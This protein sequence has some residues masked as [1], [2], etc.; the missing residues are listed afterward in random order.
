M[1]NLYNIKKL[2]IKRYIMVFKSSITKEVLYTFIN[3]AWR[4]ISGPL[5]LIFIP[6][7]LTPQIQGYWYTFG[8]LAALSVLADLGFTTIVSQFSA[9]EFA[10]LKFG[11][12]ELLEG[13]ED[14]LKRLGS[15]LRFVSKWAGSVCLVAFPVI[16]TTGFLM[17]SSKN[18]GNGW[19][20]PWILYILSSA[21]SFITGVSLSFYEGCNQIGP[22]QK[23][24]LISSIITT[25]STWV[26]LY[27]GFGLFTLSITALIGSLLNAGLLYWRFNKSLL[28]LLRISK[29]VT[30][31][32]RHEFL[33][34][35]W[36]YAISWSSGYF[37]FQIY[38]PL[39]FQ[40]HGP[41]YAGK[42]GI[43]MSLCNAIYSI[44]NVWVYTAT[45]KINMS[46]SKKDWVGL[47]R[48]A[49]KNIGMSAVTF[50]LGAGFLLAILV[51][52]KQSWTFLD[53]FLGTLPIA[54][55]LVSWLLQTFV[56]GLAI[57]LRAHKKEPFVMPSLISAIYIAVSTY[58][59]ARYLHVDF[60]FL[61]FLSS[62]LFGLPWCI[63]IF[64]T[65]RSE[66]HSL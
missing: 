4:I 22:I 46:A 66:W 61:G 50:T 35:I 18:D 3:L 11:N 41:V 52:F 15:L 8:S 44:A 7:F 39:M 38:T 33:D 20:I 65:K 23:N 59:I 19:I 37:I 42:V 26:M 51:V 10:F 40:F 27:L 28:Q 64:I 13:E 55:L 12:S 17:F 14:R 56:N 43:S 48:L 25:F 5:T 60:L 54:M 36:R 34:L 9:H 21:L 49:L 24:R 62:F 30:H 57:Y 47:D 58:F 63:W 16:L 45:P 31:N 1:Y 29:N 53:R 2:N 6:L 32:W